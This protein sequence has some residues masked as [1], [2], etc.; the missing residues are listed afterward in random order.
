LRQSGIGVTAKFIT[1][2]DKHEKYVRTIFQKCGRGIFGGFV[3]KRR[4]VAS[5]FGMQIKIGKSNNKTKKN[6]KI[7]K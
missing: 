2:E 4:G 3:C 5:V 7:F 6:L 1:V